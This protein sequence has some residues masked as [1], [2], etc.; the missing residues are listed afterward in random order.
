MESRIKKF[1]PRC[2]F[3]YAVARY[4]AYSTVWT[5]CQEYCSGQ[6]HPPMVEAWGRIA[7]LQHELD[8]HKRSTS[9]HNCAS[10]PVN[11]TFEPLI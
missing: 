5:T 8:P 11:R 7:A 9:L 4:S 6:G 10:N 2:V 3:R 1:A